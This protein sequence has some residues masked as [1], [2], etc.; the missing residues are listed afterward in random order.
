MSRLRELLVE[1]RDLVA[2]FEPDRWSGAGCAEIA[3]EL[4]ATGKACVAA[5]TACWCSGGGVQRAA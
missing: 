3:E 5:S 1:V 4:A 2:G